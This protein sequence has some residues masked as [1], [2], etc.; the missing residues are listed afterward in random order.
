[1][2]LKRWITAIVGVPLLT[3]FILTG[4]KIFG[5]LI[6]V[7][8]LIAL[9]E[10]F[11]IVFNNTERQTF[12]STSFSGFIVSPLI[13]CAAYNNSFNL[14]TGLIVLNFF[15]TGAVAVVKYRTD[16]S[17]LEAAF[18]NALGIVYIPL[19]LSY[20]VIIRN[21]S[22]GIAWS[23]FLLILIFSCDTGAY[24]VGSYLGKHKLWPSVSPGKTIE[25][26]IGGLVASLFTGFIFRYFFLS[27]MEWTITAIF[28]ICISIVGPMGDLFESVL[29]RVGKIKD[30]GA[31]LPGHGGILDRIDALLFAAPVAY[32]FKEYIL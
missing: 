7:I 28:I 12:S 29:K 13:I 24:Y 21:G 9:W 3:I 8:S 30:S 25:G 2:H 26:A 20:I 23:F 6:G 14:I 16:K 17:T 10:Y 1:M 19:L 31:I 15:L 22:N 32:L 27:Q 11:R 18:K 5:S 4:G